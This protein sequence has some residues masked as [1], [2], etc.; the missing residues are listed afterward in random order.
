M[1]QTTLPQ[2]MSYYIA[3]PLAQPTTLRWGENYKIQP[4]VEELQYLIRKICPSEVMSP[5]FQVAL[6]LCKKAK[7]LLPYISI[8]TILT[9]HASLVHFFKRELI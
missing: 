8:C 4:L 1:S 9:E 5:N 2:E 7:Q 3:Q 6:P